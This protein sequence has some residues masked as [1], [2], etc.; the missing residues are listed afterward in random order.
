MLHEEWMRSLKVGDTICD[1]REKHLKIIEIEESHMPKRSL[2]FLLG[3]VLN[4]P[5][6]E[7]LYDFFY[8]RWPTEVADKDLLLEDGSRCSAMSCAD[9]VPHDWKHEEN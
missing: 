4:F 3:W 6:S 5:Y 7:Y 2:N 1:C 9:P 8:D